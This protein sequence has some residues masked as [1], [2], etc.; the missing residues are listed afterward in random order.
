MGESCF[1]SSHDKLKGGVINLQIDN[2]IS[3]EQIL[4][5][6]LFTDFQVIPLETKDDCIFSHID[7]FKFIND[8]IYIFDR[9]TT[10]SIYLFSKEGKFLNKIC[11][12]GRGPGEYI[13]PSDFDIDTFDNCVAILDHTSRNLIF[14]DFQGNHLKSISLNEKFQSFVINKNDIY[15]FRP[16]PP[17]S[18]N[19]YNDQL[20][21]RVDRNGDILSKQIKY[22]EIKKG[23]R[24]VQFFNGGNFFIGENDIKFFMPF[25]DTIFSINGD[26]LKPFISLNTKKFKVTNEDL[27]D[28]KKKLNPML[29]RMDKLSHIREYSENQHIA[30]FKFFINV[31]EYKTFYYFKSKKAICTCR[32]VDDL[33][34]VDPWLFRLENNIMLAAI[35]P[36]QIPKFKDAISS[37]KVRLPEEMKAEL[38][39]ISDYNNPIIVLFHVR[40]NQY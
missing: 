23:P 20:I 6:E 11:K 33:T 2:L 27:V 18:V 36:I 34:F 7:N 16:Y 24:V 25:C 26:T 14:Y 28:I 4:Y 29:L 15:F 32:I 13:T 10:K 17:H 8:T 22:S 31:R 12:I 40:E 21:F 3:D 38:L 5:S 9:F 30:F 19:K 37:G 1:L 35:N 39:T